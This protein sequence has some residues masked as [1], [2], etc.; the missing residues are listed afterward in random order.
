MSFDKDPFAKSHVSWKL[1]AAVGLCVVVAIAGVSWAFVSWQGTVSG[2]VARKFSVWDSS[3]GGT[4]LNPSINVGV[5]DN[6]SM[7]MQFWIENDGS[8]GLSMTVTSESSSNCVASWTLPSGIVAG[9]RGKAVLTL[10]VTDSPFSYSW[11]F[12]PA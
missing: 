7:V 2:T 3:Q 9:V 11:T 1:L 5:L 8:I 12:T 10:N 6:N 4:Q